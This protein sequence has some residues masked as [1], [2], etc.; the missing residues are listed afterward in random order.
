LSQ[1]ALD[2]GA[3]ACMLFTDRANATSNAIY[4]R[5]GYRP[6]TTACEYRFHH[7]GKAPP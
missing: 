2:A 6:V 4:Q 5:I 7:P 3:T 1:Q